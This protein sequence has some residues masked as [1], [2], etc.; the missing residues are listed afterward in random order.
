MC[1][2]ESVGNQ[3]S[4]KLTLMGHESNALQS[5]LQQNFLSEVKIFSRNLKV[6]HLIVYGFTSLL[7]V[8]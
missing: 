2:G 5:R 6:T 4:G 1:L 7:P 3:A 8:K